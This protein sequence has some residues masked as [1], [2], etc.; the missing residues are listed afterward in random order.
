MV[1]PVLRLMI[2]VIKNPV[3]HVMLLKYV[4][5]MGAIRKQAE[6]IGKRLTNYALVEKVEF[7][8][9]VD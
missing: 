1:I 7:Q 4:I 8:R 2:P 3:V 6:D 5:E 9:S